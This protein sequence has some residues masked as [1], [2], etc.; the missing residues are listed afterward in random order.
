MKILLSKADCNR[1][2]DHLDKGET[3]RLTFN[4]FC[5]IVEET[6]KKNTDAYKIQEIEENIHE[7]LRKEKEKERE[8]Q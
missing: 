8:I 7:K 4:T 3:G 2:F 5:S 1:I 6:S